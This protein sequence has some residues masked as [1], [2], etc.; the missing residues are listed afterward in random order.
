MKI[1]IITWGT[2][3]DIRP[4]VALGL[5][6]KDEGHHVQLATIPNHQEFVT[7][8][9]LEFAALE[10]NNLKNNDGYRIGKGLKPLRMVRLYANLLKPFE[11]SFLPVLWEICQQTD[12]I[13]VAPIAIVAGFEIAQRLDIPCYAACLQPHHPTRAYPHP[14]ISIGS[15]GSI[16]NQLTYLFFDQLL[17]Q[18]VRQPVNQWRRHTLNLP[19]LSLFSGVIR[20]MHRYQTPCLYSYSPSVLPKPSDWPDWLHVTG[21]WFLDQSAHWEPPTELVDFISA[22]SPPIYIETWHPEFDTQLLQDV[23]A[24]TKKRAIVRTTQGGFRN[25]Q[26]PDEAFGIESVPHDWLFPQMAAVVHHGGTGTTMTSLRAGVPTITIPFNGDHFLWSDRVAKLGAGPPPV[27][28][29]SA[30]V[31]SERIQTAVS[32]E[33]MKHKAAVLGQQ[34]QAEN[35]VAR[36]VEL[37]HHHLNQ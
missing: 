20:R 12:A 4:Y 1:T 14:H 5:G 30:E 7:S 29:L 3:G 32:D 33:E 16:Y 35:G 15:R 17:W 8:C 34:I 9:G 26:L 23:L 24:R 21:Y 27:K 18:S 31:L 28:Q 25:A 6:L 13:I 2:H 10:F 11:E 37:F 36:A 19:S 22:G